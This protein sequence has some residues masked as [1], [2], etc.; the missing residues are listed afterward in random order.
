MKLLVGLGNPG[1]EYS[2]NRHN[3]GFL[4]LNHFA[5]SHRLAFSLRQSKARV[6]KG[7]VGGE[8]VILAKPTTYMNL[9]G[10]AV[11]SLVRQWKIAL[12]DILIIHDDMD[13]PL[14]K[15]RLKPKGSAAGHH[16]IESIIA[17]LGSQDFPRLRIGIGRPGDTGGTI[18]YVLGDILPYEREL[19]E[20]VIPSVSKAIDCFIAE[21]LEKAVRG[22]FR[23]RQWIE[24]DKDLDPLRGE[25]RYR[26]LL[27]DAKLFED[28]K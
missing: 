12:S 19:V 14:G 13:L 3:M 10:A 27:A 8:P 5:K 11:A 22:G 2:R 17:S 21:W 1:S 23:D 4:C 9:S 6:A 24:R 26:A 18:D 15:I 16:G 28:P 25:E 20:E 7:E